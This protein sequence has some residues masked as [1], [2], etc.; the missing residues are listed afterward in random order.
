MTFGFD[1]T[2]TNGTSDDPSGSNLESL[3][4]ERWVPTQ[5]AF[6]KLLQHLGSNREE[7]GKEYEIMRVKLV[8]FFEWRGCDAADFRA[9]QTIDRVMRRIDEGQVISNLMGYVYGVAKLVSK[10]VIRE[11]DRMESLSDD[12]SSPADSPQTSSEETDR[13]FACF[14]QCMATLSSDARELIIKY[15]QEEKHAKIVGRKQLAEQLGI[16]LNALR[17]RVHRIRKTLEECIQNCL[18][19]PDLV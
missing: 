2:P 15:Y 18:A 14:D 12:P 5:K 19:Q 9:D 7:A 3:R 16:P 10:E 8:R 1:S 4:K 17:I 6:D 11:K 13:R